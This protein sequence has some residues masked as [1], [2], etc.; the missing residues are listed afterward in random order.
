MKNKV[1]GR[2]EKLM[3]IFNTFSKS[4]NQKEDW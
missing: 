2:G 3:K 1:G 4:G